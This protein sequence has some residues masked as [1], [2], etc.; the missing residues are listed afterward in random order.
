MSNT[1]LNM[2][3]YTWG[4]KTRGGL[5][6]TYNMSQEE[7]DRCAEES[8]GMF[9]SAPVSTHHYIPYQFRT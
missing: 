7:A 2:P 6:Y 1:S 5:V 4:L 8:K 3:K 9:I